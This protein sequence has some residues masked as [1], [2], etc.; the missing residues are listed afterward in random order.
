[1]TIQCTKSE[2]VIRQ[3][4]VAIDLLFS[5][6]D[7]LAIRTLISAAHGILADLVERTTPGESWRSNMIE[8]SGL[9]KG[10][11][12][13]LINGTANYLKHADRDANSTLSLS[14]EEND[15]VMFV[16]TLECAK[17]E[18]PLSHKMQAYQIW[19]LASYPEKIGRATEIVEVSLKALPDLELLERSKRLDRG[20]KF[21]QATNVAT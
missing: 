5:G 12:L 19:Y 9:S 1:M 21:I 10:A 13:I 17:L 3:L 2:A 14:E 15:D 16:A 18:Y 20:A 6:S 7:P 11:A 8:E 4:D